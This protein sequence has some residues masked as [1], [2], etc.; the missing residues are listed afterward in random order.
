MTAEKRRTRKKRA[1][2]Y[3]SAAVIGVVVYVFSCFVGRFEVCWH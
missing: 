2:G 3:V 1:A